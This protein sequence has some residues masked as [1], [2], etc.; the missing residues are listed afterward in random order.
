MSDTETHPAIP[1]DP[2]SAVCCGGGDEA[3]GCSQNSPDGVKR[4]GP[5]DG[6]PT[7]LDWKQVLTAFREQSTPFEVARP[8]YTLRGRTLGNGPPLYLLCGMG[9]TA[10]SFC[11]V[12]YL[13]RDLFRCVVFDYPGTFDAVRPSRKVTLN[14]LRDDLLAVAD[15]Q[16]DE[17]F[18]LFATSFGS[19]VALESMLAAPDRITRAVLQGAFARRQLSFAERAI[20]RLGGFLPGKLKSLPGAKTVQEQ[21]HRRWFPPLDTT[22]WQFFADDAGQVPIRSMARRGAIIRQTDLR[23]KLAQIQQ[24]LLLIQSEGDG[25]VTR[26][27]H[28]AL[29][30]GLPHAT[31]AWM[32]SAGHLPQL[33]SPHRLAKFLRDFLLPQPTDA[34]A[35]P[36]VAPCH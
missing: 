22:R 35:T 3:H 25:L 7:P 24:P 36:A 31:V 9:G 17:Q 34:E 26:E 14:S 4:P 10:D 27:C 32:H 33:T 8:G 20:I 18:S 29:A 15:Q 1:G 19:L 21:N 5:L 2:E 12:A 23:P 16:G 28:E 11:L 30:K 6:C 13:L